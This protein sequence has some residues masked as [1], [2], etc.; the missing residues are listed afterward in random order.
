[1]PNHI[2][3]RY[4]TLLQ[5]E[6]G[7]TPVPFGSRQW[8][9]ALAYA[10]TYYLGMSNLGVHSLYQLMNHDPE[11]SCERV[12]LPEPGDEEALRTS[13][14]E[15]FSLESQTPVAQFD[16][17]AFS[18]AFEP[19]YLNLPKIFEMARIPALSRD[20]DESHPL[21][22]A[23]GAAIF[24]N[25]EPVA[26]FF[27]AIFVG[28]AEVLVPEFLKILK[29]NTGGNGSASS[30]RQDLLARLAEMPG[31]YV[32]AL[33]SEQSAPVKRQKLDGTMDE[34]TPAT[35]ILTANT[36]F[37]NKFM[38]EI[39]RGCP[40]GCRFCWAG[41]SYRRPKMA[42]A[43]SILRMAA[44]ARSR[45]N[46][47][48]LVATAV[49]DHP[50]IED[51]LGGL[52]NLDYQIAVA[53][54]RLEQISPRLL[55]SLVR[56]HDQQVTVAP[57]TGTDRLRQV[58]NK[59]L[60]NDQ[61]KG[62]CR[63]IFEEGILNLKLYFM[64]GLPTEMHEDIAGIVDFVK[65]LQAIM[66]EASRRHGR[67]GSLVI[68]LN[69]FVPK[70]NTPFQWVEVEDEKTLQG[71]IDFI[72]RGL[73]GVPN[74]RVNAMRPREAHLQSILSL[75]DRS[76]SSFILRTHERQGHW[77][78]AARDLG[79]QAHHFTRTRPNFKEKL[80]WEVMDLGISKLFL[81]SEWKQAMDAKFSAPCP[82]V[83]G[84][85][86]CGV[87]PP[88][89]IVETSPKDQASDQRLKPPPHVTRPWVPP[90]A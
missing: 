63:S 80:P 78:K 39:S 5:Q 61:I 69:C 30:K 66:V 28:E 19:D 77:R 38:I 41:Y 84:C 11:V 71:K 34:F 52:E 75:G 76:L 88:A 45:T 1:M 67:L 86:H 22:I 47:I 20:R 4:E 65:E 3:S 56:S 2:R 60:T 8:N 13:G 17:L 46:K 62:I 81:M 73:G 70:P 51:I 83:D 15:L 6:W 27:D 23:G 87:C 32:P 85:V 44:A 29:S 50:E 74:V 82:D 59:H 53:S 89:S 24:L 42:S 43:S 72:V 21:V 12:F 54:L 68:S 57:E 79:I 48:G 49:L 31:C 14:L 9:V 55:R 58:V 33:H 25:P 37:S 18:I 16:V 90:P 26:D 35:Q 10:N 64:V 7:A 40:A 36:E